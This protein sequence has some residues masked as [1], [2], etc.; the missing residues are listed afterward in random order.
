MSKKP[1]IIFHLDMDHFYTA[2]EERENPA[3]KGKPVVV[4]ADP[5]EGRGRGVV[6]TS[7]YEAR[8][9]GVRSGMPISRA[10]KLCPEAVYLQPNFP[11]YIKASNAVMEIARRYADKFEQ[12]GIDE[13]F[14]DVSAK[15]KDY[16]EAEALAKQI[17]REINEKE[18]LTCSIGVGPNKLVAKIA[19]DIQKPDGLT[20]VKEE[21]VERFLAPL[22]V[23]KLLWVGRKT[24]VKLKTMGVSTI[25]DLARLDPSVLTETFG[26]MG[27]QMHLMARGIDRSEVEQRTEVKSISHET[28]FEEDVGDPDIVLR[29]LDDLSEAV[30]REAADQSFFFKTVTI[31]VRYENFETHTH[32]KTLP[33][34]TNRPQDLK[35]TARELLQG[36]LRR[37]RKI[38]LIGVRV[39][40]F[41][42]GEKQKTLV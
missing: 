5:K 28:T 32:S 24:E 6:S 19:S 27:L 40:S 11:L 21:E 39:S 34:M 12:W 36:Y 33:F 42:S 22:P 31:K 8:K 10:W 18:K 38:R 26:V 1:R 25:G 2:V 17:K 29:A 13:A 7:N 30:S 9:S 23:R 15:V 20:I 14:L 3:L 4:G 41:V 16:T 35:K 37:D